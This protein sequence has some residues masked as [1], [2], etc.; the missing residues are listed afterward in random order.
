MPLLETRMKKPHFG[1]VIVLIIIQSNALA[2]IVGNDYHIFNSQGINK[3]L[4]YITFGDT[5]K[6]PTHRNNT[7]EWFYN[8]LNQDSSTF[9][10]QD[11]IDVI[12]KSMLTWS[13][14][15][16]INFIFKGKTDSNINNPTDGIFTIGYWSEISFIKDYG[17]TAG[18]TG[19]TW[20]EYTITEGFMVLNAGNNNA[21][22]T[23]PAN[24]TQLQGLITHE[25]GHLLAIDHSNVEESIM[26][27]NPYHSFEYQAVLQD[28]DIKVA[29][30]LYPSKISNSSTTVS[31]NLD[32]NIQSATYQSSEGTLNIWANLEYKGVDSDGDLIW[33]LKDFG[34]K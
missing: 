29:S 33:K 24:L 5:N 32:I 21:G 2:E 23:V 20:E 19:V 3:Q 28:D 12:K 7:V 13:N 34:E 8:S 26:Y 25:V 6:P 31:E 27:A 16:G 30:L 1:F 17:M 4:K 11:V 10:E 15:S 9:S 22:S 14:I 18:H